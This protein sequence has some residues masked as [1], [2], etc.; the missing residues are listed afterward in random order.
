MFNFDSKLAGKYLS[1]IYAISSVITPL[2]GY[3]IDKYGR[4][5]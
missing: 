4:I 5:A 2:M 1:I 3:I